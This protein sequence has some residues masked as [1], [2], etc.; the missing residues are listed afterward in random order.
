MTTGIDKM[1]IGETAEEVGI[2]TTTGTETE[3]GIEA[4]IEIEIEAG[5]ETAIDT[6]IEIETETERNAK[7]DGKREAVTRQTETM[8]VKI[9]RTVVESV[10]ANPSF[11]SSADDLL[12]GHRA[13]CFLR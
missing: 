13:L 10:D 7:T 4:G 3:T 1:T 9:D 6:M 8:M 5:I 2:A 12:S 11:S